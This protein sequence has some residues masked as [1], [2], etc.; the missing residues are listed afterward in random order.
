ANME[1]SE[2][3]RVQKIYGME[4]RGTQKVFGEKIQGIKLKLKSGKSV[5]GFALPERD[6]SG[7]KAIKTAGVPLMLI[8]EYDIEATEKF[9]AYESDFFSPAEIYQ[10]W[11]L[12]K[13]PG[14]ND[15]V[16]HFAMAQ[17]V[18]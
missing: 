17:K 9:D 14:T 1:E 13:P 12:E 16:A 6:Q 11:V 15:A 7:K 8:P 10:K 4:V 3:K 2:R 5:E 18:A